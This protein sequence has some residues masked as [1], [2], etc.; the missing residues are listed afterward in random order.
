MVYH[1]RIHKETKGFWAECL[2][3]DGCITQGD[4]LGELAQNAEEA[5]N[6]YLS[7]PEESKKVFPLPEEHPGKKPIL[8]VQVRPSVALAVMLRFLRSEKGLTQ[9]KVAT[10]LGF[11]STYAYQK[12]ESPKTCNPELSTLSKLKKVFPELMIDL[13]VVSEE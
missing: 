13:I 7:E 2:E 11:N 1:F 5:L 3:L 9:A 8:A 12:L 4:T 10:Q 6:L